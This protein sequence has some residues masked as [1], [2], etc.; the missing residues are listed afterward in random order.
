MK[1]ADELYKE[2]GFTD[3]IMLPKHMVIM[4]MIKYGSKVVDRC[5]ESA[6]TACDVVDGIPYNYR[7]NKQSILNVKTELK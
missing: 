7:V 2:N 3:E 4:L 5:A 6:E 1:T